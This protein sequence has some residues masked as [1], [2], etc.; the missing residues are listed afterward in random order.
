M[1]FR[2][3]PKSSTSDDLKR[4][5]RTMVQKRCVFWSLLHKYEWKWTYTI[6]GKN[7][8]HCSSFWEI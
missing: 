4:Q 7:V 1:R 6:S 2:L 8:G 5:K 3:V